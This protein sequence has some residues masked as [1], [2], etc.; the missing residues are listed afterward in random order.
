MRFEIE[1]DPQV[2][3]FLHDHAMDGIPLLP[4]VMGIEG[5]A[6]VASLIA[7]DL[8][9]AGECFAVASIEDVNFESPLK[10]YRQQPRKATWRAVV[11]PDVSGPDVSGPNTSGP[12]T[13]NPGLVAHVTLESTREIA[14]TQSQQH[15]VHFSGRVH[16]VPLPKDTDSAPATYPPSWNGEA[17]VAPEAIYRVYFHGPA[18][19]VLDGVQAG[20]ERVVG[21]MRTDLPPMTGESKQTLTPP[22]LIELCLQTAGVWEIGKTGTLA[23]PTAIDRVVIHHRPENGSLLYAEMEPKTGP[24]DKV[25]FDGHVVDEQGTVCVELYGYRTARLPDPIGE[26]KAAPLRAAIEE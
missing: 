12:D 4:G 9:C 7:S 18:F 6:E 3:P 8:G 25:Q 20:H 24:G 2:E 17:T 14:A 5:F 21:R 26:E 19:Q 15:A 23:L 11:M 16:L 13:Q 1:L 10:F 22:L